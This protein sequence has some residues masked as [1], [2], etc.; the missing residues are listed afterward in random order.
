M[1]M[2][3][4]TLQDIADINASINDVN[5]AITVIEGI[6]KLRTF[7]TVDD[8]TLYLP[9]SYQILPGTNITF[10]TTIPNEITINSTGGAVGDNVPLATGAEPLE[11][12][13]DGAG[14]CF[15]VGFTPP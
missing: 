15:L 4:V 6:L 13:S 3:G 9:N 12:M 5:T 11:I 2:Q 1:Q 7:I 14:S 8:E 10:D